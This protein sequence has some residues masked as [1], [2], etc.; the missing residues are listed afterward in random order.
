MR[1]ILLLMT[2]LALTPVAYGNVYKCKMPDGQI[3]YK[4]KPCSVGSKEYG[5]YPVNR[6]SWKGSDAAVKLKQQPQAET[7]SLDVPNLSSPSADSSLMSMS[8][9]K[10]RKSCRPRRQAK[11][12]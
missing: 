1:T 3:Q 12:I 7:Y 4:D 10:V 5:V 2:M 8:S 9:F 11:A 6:A